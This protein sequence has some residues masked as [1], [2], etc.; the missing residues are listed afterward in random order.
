MEGNLAIYNKITQA[1]TFEPTIPL[2]GIYSEDT[3]LIHTQKNTYA[4]D[5][6]LYVD[7]YFL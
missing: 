4:L 7:E 5:Y 2:L 6:S 1:I 3:L